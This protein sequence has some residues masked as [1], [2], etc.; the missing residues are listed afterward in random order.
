MATFPSALKTTFTVSSSAVLVR[1]IL[2]CSNRKPKGFTL[3]MCL[4]SLLRQRIMNGNKSLGFSYGSSH[5]SYFLLVYVYVCER[6]Q[7]CRSHGTCIDVGAQ[8]SE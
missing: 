6:L 4:N 2:V 5:I 1:V 3:L 8:R 7:L